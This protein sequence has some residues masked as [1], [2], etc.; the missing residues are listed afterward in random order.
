MRETESDLQTAEIE[1]TPTAPTARGGILPSTFRLRAFIVGVLLIPIDNYW[2]FEMD[3]LGRGPGVTMISLFANAIFI[4]ALMLLVNQLIRKLAP[5]QVFSQMEMLVI[6]T[7]ICIGTAF[8]AQDWMA[9]LIQMIGHPYYFAKPENQWGT[10]IVPFIPKPGLVTIKDMFVLDG[11]YKGDSS[12]GLYRWAYLTAWF[13]PVMIWSLFVTVLLYVMMCINVMVRKQWM[14]RERLTFPIAQLPIAM[15]EPESSFWKNRLLWIGFSIAAAYTII[16]GLHFLYPSV[17]L[18]YD[19]FGPSSDLRNFMVT[20]PWTGIDRLPVRFHPFVTG[21]GFLLPTDLLFSCWFFYFVWKAQMVLTTAMAWDAIPNFPFINQQSYGGYMAV[22]AGLLWTGRSYFK[23]VWLRIIGKPSELDDSAEAMSYR[24]AAIGIVL[25]TIALAGF[26]NWLGL[27]FAIAFIG[28][29]IYWGI[30]VAVARI[31]AE[32]GPP[33]H[34]MHGASPSILITQFMG[35]KHTGI[36]DARGL[37]AL[38]YFWWFNRA[39]RQ[40]PIAFEL[41]GMRMANT[42]RASQKRL[43]VAVIIAA[44]VG[45]VA[46]FWAYLHFAYQMGYTNKIAGGTFRGDDIFGKQLYN[47]IA[48][49]TGPNMQANLAVLFGFVFCL[50]LGALRLRW[51]G[52]PFHPIGYAISGTWSMNFVWL[53]LLIAWIIKMIILRMGGLKLFKSA[54]P[55]FLGLILGEMIVGCLWSLVGIAFGIPTYSF[56]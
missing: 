26:F 11:F 30:S 40:H 29:L 56:W 14:E 42:V 39:Y 7:M 53:P 46:A 3:R 23:Q 43:L 48:N 4:L 35:T 21:L 36:M 12:Y 6:Y 54:V 32:L 33:V 31:R 13:K 1:P 9:N 20:K 15:T 50:I 8:T 37:A 34:D 55:F 49:P 18:I 28:F 45:S 51:F 47:W 38:S 24:S 41:E 44:F 2:V 22:L 52:F 5:R 25:G 17:P 10:Y 16:N 27:N 19:N